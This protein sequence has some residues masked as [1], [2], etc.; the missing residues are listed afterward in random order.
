MLIS[1]SLIRASVIVSIKNNGSKI[2]D[3]G[4][5][6]VYKIE[7]EIINERFLWMYCEYDNKEFY[8]EYVYNNKTDEEE[9]N[10]RTKSQLE[11]RN[12]LFVC[13]DVEGKLLYFSDNKRKPFIED[14]FKDSLGKDIT[15]KNIY[16][17]IEEFN[18]SMKVLKEVRFIQ[19]DN[20]ISRGSSSI[21]QEVSNLFGFNFHKSLNLKLEIGESITEKTKNTLTN[22]KTRKDKGEF[23]E[24]ILIGYDDKK[25][26][27]RF[28]YT[29]KLKKIN[30]EVSRNENYRYVNENIRKSF[31]EKLEELNG[32]KTY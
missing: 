1:V 32:E 6:L 17:S 19:K 31:L 29:S 21:F 30:L 2:F 13:Y 7:N 4:K 10:P 8:N 16:S 15:I 11:M 9:T 25:V 14:Y 20:L 5:T 18:E 27:Q 24:I 22:L 12:Q 3:K 23:E 26:E 28:D